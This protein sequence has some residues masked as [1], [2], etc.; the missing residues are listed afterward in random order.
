M[1]TYPPTPRLDLVEQMHGVAVPDPYRWLEDPTDERTATWA[2][3]QG[4]LM[5]KERESWQT[6]D[7]FVERVE[8]LLGAG[9]IS[10]TYWA[11]LRRLP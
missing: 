5:D 8:Q 9:S 11:L 1:T 6:R 4:E 7:R 3:G 10:P 2:A